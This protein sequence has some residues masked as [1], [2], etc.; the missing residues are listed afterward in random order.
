MNYCKFALHCRLR[1]CANVLCARTNPLAA[2]EIAGDSEETCDS[3]ISGN[4][5]SRDDGKEG[6]GEELRTAIAELRNETK[7]DKLVVSSNKS[8]T[9]CRC[10]AREKWKVRVSLVFWLGER[11]NVECLGEIFS[12]QGLLHAG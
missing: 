11:K 9:R 12:S 2:W 1:L 10:I 6:G 4:S 3:P 8:I 5:K 7:R